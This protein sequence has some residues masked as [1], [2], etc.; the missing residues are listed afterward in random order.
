MKVC[1]YLGQRCEWKVQLQWTGQRV[2]FIKSRSEFCVRILLHVDHTLVFTP[3][4]GFKVYVFRKKTSFS[5]VFDCKR[6]RDGPV[7]DARR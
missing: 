5:S 7:A 2:R 1:L 6:H 3:D 4:D